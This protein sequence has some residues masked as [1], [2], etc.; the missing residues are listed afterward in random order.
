MAN[1]EFSVS[2]VI[3]HS[4]ISAGDLEI[5]SRVGQM[6]TVSPAAR[7]RCGVSSELCR[8]GAKPWRWIPPVVTRFGVI[9]RILY[10]EDLVFDLIQK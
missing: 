4:T 8:L 1:K 7:H 2:S 10:N 3:K 6:D 5:D 9:P